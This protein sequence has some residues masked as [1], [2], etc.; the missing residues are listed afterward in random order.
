MTALASLLERPDAEDPMTAIAAWFDEHDHDTRQAALAALGRVGQRRLYE[1]ASYAPA[2]TLADLHAGVAPRH[3][4]PWTGQNTLPLPATFGRFQKVFCR[5][6][7][8]S[9]RLFGFNEGASRPLLGPGYY[10]AYACEDP[11]WRARGPIVV[12]YFQVPDAPVVDGWPRVVSNSR[13]LQ[14]FVFRGTRDYL[15]RVSRRVAI[16]AAYKGES[17]LDH[18][19]TLNLPDNTLGDNTVGDTVSG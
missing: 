2:L 6:D 10:V 17:P 13:G 5:P 11:V 3:A 8:G 1:L 15:R 9:A 18:Y 4:I 16:G 12:D 19:F 7:D 14:W